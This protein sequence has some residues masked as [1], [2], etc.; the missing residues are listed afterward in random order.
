MS[1]FRSAMGLDPGAVR[2][3]L[4]VDN[5]GG[6]DSDKK[7]DFFVKY[8]P[9]DVK[10]MELIE[11]LYDEES[12]IQSAN[13]LMSHHN[14]GKR[15]NVKFSGQELDDNKY[16][17]LA[18]IEDLLE[19][20]RRHK[21]KFGFVLVQDL[22]AYLDNQVREIL[23][24]PIVD[25][26]DTSAPAVAN[27]AAQRRSDLFGREGDSTST[28]LDAVQKRTELASM[29]IHRAAAMLGE[30]DPRDKLLGAG[31]NSQLRDN[32]I[33]GREGQEQTVP[34][35]SGRETV[36]VRQDQR[37][38]TLQAPNAT[39]VVVREGEGKSGTAEERK[40]RRS[41]RRVAVSRSF[42]EVFSSM[43]DVQVVNWKDGRLFLR[44]DQLTST[45][46][47]VFCRSTEDLDEA[48]AEYRQAIEQ[49]KLPRA[50]REDPN[51]KVFVW[52]NR[53][54]DDK[55]RIKS[56]MMELIYL[57]NKWS[58][59]DRRLEMADE[60]NAQPTVYLS[61]DEKITPESTKDA[62]EQQLFSAPS[63]IGAGA[64]RL[65]ARNVVQNYRLMV[66]ANVANG[67]AASELDRAI[68]E[69]V[70]KPSTE[71]PGTKKLPPKAPN[72]NLFPLPRGYS[73]SQVVT[74]STIDD[75][76]RRKLEY[77]TRVASTM[78]IPLSLLEG[79]G[80]GGKAGGS[81]TNVTSSAAA[82]VG[83]LFRATILKD[84]EDLELFFSE[85][86]DVLYR[87]LDT[88]AFG[89]LLAQVRIEKR[90]KQELAA[91]KQANLLQQYRLIT[92]AAEEVR[93]TRAIADSE[94]YLTSL[95]A[96][97]SRLEQQIRDINSLEYRVT[98]HFEKFLFI[99]SEELLE[100]KATGAISGLEY[101][102]VLRT[103]MAM[104]PLTEQEY[105]QNKAAMLEES[106]KEM[107]A[108]QPPQKLA[109]GGGGGGGSSSASSA[110]KPAASSAA[111]RPSSAVSASTNG[112][113]TKRARTDASK[114]ASTGK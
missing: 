89:R 78:G 56:G 33:V 29:H 85:I 102:N 98:I 109:T 80:S 38:S 54:P 96:H 9:L 26:D 45:R 37:S 97:Y 49:N 47:V 15:F 21:H 25:D 32:D 52:P 5:G 16:H 79:G 107:M 73:V 61:Y 65:D 18:P 44:I 64:H 34:S 22:N 82:I 83:D 30:P 12:L 106:H 63:S 101:A 77:Q 57:R 75:V 51:V 42:D 105:E 113:E 10:Q 74:G 110:K 1:I 20:A 104:P 11:D 2:T 84:R 50:L 39:A 53:M 13:N 99:T 35:A 87:K 90:S 19:K 4:G 100:A 46:S 27:A 6:F 69:G 94:A 7:S 93:Q 86:Y 112:K 36:I 3:T 95:I 58:N 88:R 8:V 43:R 28:D 60:S 81:S 76:E 108:I 55:G 40:Q 71:G 14:L 103:K 62:T 91:K 66:A 59:A 17:H 111:K 68:A 48:E 72:Q 23:D 67:K 70:L 31:G 24:E 92:D 114:Q 41:K